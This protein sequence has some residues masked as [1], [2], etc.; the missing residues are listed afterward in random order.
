MYE[1]FREMPRREQPRLGRALSSYL[2]LSLSL[3]VRLFQSA[4][5]RAR[6]R[7]DPR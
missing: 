3:L 4:R 1:I 5:A 2:S 7:D 6:T